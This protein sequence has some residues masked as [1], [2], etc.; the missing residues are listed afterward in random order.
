MYRAYI[1]TR[2][3]LPGGQSNRVIE[4]ATLHGLKTACAQ[5]LWLDLEWPRSIKPGHYFRAASAV[6]AIEIYKTRMAMV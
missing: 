1:E 6:G 5:Y 2:P 4:S 3:Y